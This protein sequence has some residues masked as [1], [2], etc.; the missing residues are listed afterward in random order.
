MDRKKNGMY[1]FLWQ[2]LFCPSCV[3]Y[4]VIS[5]IVSRIKN[6]KSDKKEK[7]VNNTKNLINSANSNIDYH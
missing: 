1:T 2:N 5:F 4:N 3:I 6:K 7:R